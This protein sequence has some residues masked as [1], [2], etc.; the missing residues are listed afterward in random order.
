VTAIGVRSGPRIALLIDDLLGDT[1][2]AAHGVDD[3]LL[4]TDDFVIGEC[5]FG[6][7]PSD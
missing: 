7:H 2:L 3:Q 5:G 4:S 6:A 1:S